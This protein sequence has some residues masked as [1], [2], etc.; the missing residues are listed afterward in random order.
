VSSLRSARTWL[1]AGA[2]S[3]LLLGLAQQ[4]RGAHFMSHT[5]W[6][7]MVCWCVAWGIDAVWSSS[8]ALARGLE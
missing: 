7:A 8:G 6:S 4:W 2:A 3:G 5:W 1:A